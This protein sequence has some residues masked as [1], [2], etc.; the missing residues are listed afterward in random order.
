MDQVLADYI[1]ANSPVNPSVLA[2]PNGRINCDRRDGLPAAHA[3]TLI[4]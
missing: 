1:T 3:I 4:G 2:P